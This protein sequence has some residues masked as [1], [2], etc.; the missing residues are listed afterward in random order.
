MHNH[1]WKHN[2]EIPPWADPAIFL[3]HFHDAG[4]IAM[5]WH[6]PVLRSDLNVGFRRAISI[7]FHPLRPSLSLSYATMVFKHHTNSTPSARPET[8]CVRPSLPSC[9]M[10]FFF[11]YL[12]R[13]RAIWPHKR[14]W[15]GRELSVNINC[16]SQ[17]LSGRTMTAISCFTFPNTLSVW[18]QSGVIPDL[19]QQL[20]RGEPDSQNHH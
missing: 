5:Q 13:L 10:V 4:C 7:I 17:G 18:N 20:R 12:V 16:M 2:Q 1:F 11:Y 15:Q 8:A 14:N 6:I 3:K 9:C 19:S